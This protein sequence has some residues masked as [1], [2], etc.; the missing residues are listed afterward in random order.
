MIGSVRARTAAASVLVVGAGVLAAGLAVT[1]LL[2]RSL[3]A[4]TD[5]SALHRAQDVAALVEAGALPARLPDPDDPDHDELL[6]QVTDP[7]GRVVAASTRMAGLPLML[8]GRPPPSGQRRTTTLVGLA[9]DPPDPFRVVAF[10]TTGPVPGYTVYAA[11]E[12]SLVAR[13]DAAL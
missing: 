1:T 4:D 5:R 2:H 12:L 3:L 9:P 7:A 11:S 8:P 13:S 10:T 6:V